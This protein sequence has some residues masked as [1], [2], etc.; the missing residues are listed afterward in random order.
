MRINSFN[1][2]YSAFLVIKAVRSEQ[3]IEQYIVEIIIQKKQNKITKR[4]A[5]IIIQSFK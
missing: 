5:T 2:W 4:E 1:E 3:I